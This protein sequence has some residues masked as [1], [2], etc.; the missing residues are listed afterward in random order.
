MLIGIII[1]VGLALAPY[2]AVTTWKQESVAE[3]QT[4]NTKLSETGRE[5]APYR[6][7]NDLT[8][9][10]YDKVIRLLESEIRDAQKARDS[11]RP[12]GGFKGW[13]VMGVYKKVDAKREKSIAAYNDVISLLKESLEG[14]KLSREAMVVMKKYEKADSIEQV[15]PMVTDMRQIADKLR[16]VTKTSSDK[17]SIALLDKVIITIEKMV[18]AYDARDKRQFTAAENEL[19]DLNKQMDELDKKAIQES[20]EFQKRIDEKSDIFMAETYSIK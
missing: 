7:R 15:R 20:R 8:A 19:K 16:I 17:E 1:L 5:L 14:A 2:L 6:E 9:E 3:N 13:D 11:L 10:D 4:Y 18:K 12:I